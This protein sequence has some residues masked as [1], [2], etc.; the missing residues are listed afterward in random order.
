[1]TQSLTLSKE[2]VFQAS[3]PIYLQDSLLKKVASIAYNIFSILIF[4]IGVFRFIYYKIHTTVGYYFLIPSQ[5][6][7]KK[8]IN[9][10]EI[11]RKNLIENFDAREITIQTAD[12]VK[13]NGLFILGKKFLRNKLD[14]NAPLVI[15]YLGNMGKYEDFSSHKKAIEALKNFNLLIVNY[16]G[17]AKSQSIA[18]RKGLILD[19]EAI[20]EF[21]LKKLK[22]SE[23]KIILHGHSF[24][25]AIATWIASHHNQ[26]KLLNDRSFSTFENAIYYVAEKKI[27]TLISYL[28]IT[29]FVLLKKVIPIKAA[30]KVDDFMKN[31]IFNN[32]LLLSNILNRINSIVSKIIA[33]CL[34]KLAVFFG[35]NFSPVS[36]WENVKGK[37]IGIFLKNDSL[38]D[39]NASLFKSFKKCDKEFISILDPTVFHT[40][41]LPTCLIERVLNQLA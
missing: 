5:F 6:V 7:S 10:L 32:N 37:K 23:N 2:L 41:A 9:E 4:P 14:E 35:W 16:R 22:V 39:Y 15:H 30:E 31:K 3:M 36:Q 1:M 33:F 27:Q 8:K 20:L 13:L 29:P 11:A 28:C 25:G 12:K 40:S 18:T 24:G 21:A 26:V 19:A 38:I 17:V 34:S